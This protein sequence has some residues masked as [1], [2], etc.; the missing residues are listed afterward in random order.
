M[1][2]INFPLFLI[3]GILPSIIWLAFYLRKDIHPEPNRM[4]LKI[5]VLGMLGTLPAIFIELQARSFFEQI[6]TPSPMVLLLYIFFGVALVEELI[7]Y[8]IVRWQVYPS[9]MLDEPID[10]P[11]YMIISALGFAAFENILILSG[12]G[13]TALSSD[14]LLLSA[15]RFMGATLLHALASGLFGYFLVLGLLHPRLK[16]WYSISGLILATALHGLFNLY[17]LET[18]FPG[19]ILFPAAI[20]IGLAIFVSFALTKLQRFEGPWRIK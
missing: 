11:L 15:F 13:P 14:I 12:L 16:F 10:L 17:I 3:F 9:G 8:A 20:L 7:K 1:A 2:S 4:V 18:A 19:K 5:F 6:F